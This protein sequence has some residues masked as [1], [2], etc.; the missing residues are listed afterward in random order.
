MPPDKS[1]KNKTQA[2]ESGQKQKK[3]E[4]GDDARVLICKRFVKPPKISQRQL[5]VWLLKEHG[6]PVAQSTISNTLRDK[7]IYLHPDFVPGTSK[8]AAKWAQLERALHEWIVAYQKSVVIT[9]MLVKKKAAQF[10]ARLTPAEDQDPEKLDPEKWTNGWLEGFQKRFKIQ[11][12]RRHGEAGSVDLDKLALALPKIQVQ[13]QKYS[14]KDTFNMDETAL[15]YRLQPDTGLATEFI[16]GG[17]KDKTRV[18]LVACCNADGSEKVEIWVLGQ[19]QNPRALNK[20]NRALL[21]CQYRANKKGWMTGQM[22]KEWLAWFDD[23]MEGR[24][25]CLLLDNASSHDSSVET[26]NVELIFLPPNTTSVIQPLDQGII[27][28]LKVHYRHKYYSDVL[29]RMEEVNRE[30]AIKRWDIL[31]TIKAVAAAWKDGVTDVTIANCFQH[32]RVKVF[33]PIEN[34]NRSVSTVAEPETS[35]H[36]PVRQ[37]SLD[38]ELSPQAADHAPVRQESLE[39]ELPA[40]EEEQLLEAELDKVIAQMGYSNRMSIAFILNQEN[41]ERT[42]ALPTDDEIL[43]AAESTPFDEEGKEAD[44]VEAR[45]KEIPHKEA[46]YAAKILEEWAYQQDDLAKA[47]HSNID[48]ALRSV[49]RLAFR[50]R[51]EKQEQKQIPDFFPRL[52]KIAAPSDSNEQSG[53]RSLP[54]EID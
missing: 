17:K 10:Y 15:L 31:D 5:K 40:R 54:M 34:P 23:Q 11:S 4:W 20:V 18:T 36:A 2:K 29:E 44:A 19:Y 48:R 12:R 50:L 7:D 21:G 45:R 6:I 43:E 16:A 13:T 53:S 37:E 27:R 33:G 42:D 49:R 26:R 3:G 38:P 30:E 32:S 25:V 39:P 28:S 1:V 24:K 41:E 46:L 14:L 22:F 35:G 52:P 47:E 9:Q 8:R 51:S